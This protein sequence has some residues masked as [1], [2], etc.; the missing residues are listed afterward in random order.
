MQGS[1]ESLSPW[2]GAIGRVAFQWGDRRGDGYPGR[3]WPGKG[4]ASETGKVFLARKDTLGSCEHCDEEA[5]DAVT[6]SRPGFTGTELALRI[7][8]RPT[9]SG[10]CPPRASSL[11]DRHRHENEQQSGTGAVT[12]L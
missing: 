2:P 11:A 12:A 3:G 5:G 6:S 9:R 10:L 8:G 7:R 1:A 4:S